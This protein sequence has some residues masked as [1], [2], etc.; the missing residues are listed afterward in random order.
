MSRFLVGTGPV[1]TKKRDIS[2]IRILRMHHILSSFQQVRSS[3]LWYQN[4]VTPTS[5][6]LN[7]A[8]KSTGNIIEKCCWCRNCCSQWS[9]ALLETCLSSSKIQ[10]IHL[11]HNVVELL[12]HETSYSFVII[13]PANITDLNSVDHRIFRCCLSEIQVATRK[14]AVFKAIHHFSGETM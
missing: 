7:L 1:P 9:A 3:L 6:P 11:A 14:P 13:W 5:F 12:C 10:P 2:A 8:L 4:Y